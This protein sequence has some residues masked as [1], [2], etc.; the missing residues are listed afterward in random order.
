VSQLEIA[1][2]G[3]F[4]RASST[5][6]VRAIEAA[7]ERVSVRWGETRPVPPPVVWQRKRAEAVQLARTALS[8]RENPLSNQLS[9]AEIPFG[10]DLRA[11]SLSKEAR[12]ALPG[13]PECLLIFRVP[14][15]VL[16]VRSIALI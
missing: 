9:W 7:S 3:G 2:P 4:A 6:L 1:G 15:F 8:Y 11:D 5:E 10:G 16:A 12:D 14:G 13:T